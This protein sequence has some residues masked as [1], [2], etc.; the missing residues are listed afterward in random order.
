MKPL[1]INKDSCSPVSSN[2]VT[3][4]GPDIECIGLC[5][6]DSIT[7]VV[8]ELA[9]KLCEILGKLDVDNYDLECLNITT[10]PPE[11]FE[12]LLQILIE[13]ICEIQ[14]TPCPPCEDGANGN[15]VV[16]AYEP[17]GENCEFGGVVITTYNGTTNLPI[18]GSAVYVCNGQDGEDGTPGTTGGPGTPG[19]RGTSG[20]N[21]DYVVQ[22]AEPAGV[23]CECGGIKIEN[24]SGVDNSLISTQYICSACNYG[25]FE[26]QSQPVSLAKVAP[27]MDTTKICVGTV[28][29][30]SEV[31]DD[32]SAYNPATG[33][34]TCPATGVYNMS[35]FINYSRETGTG[36]FDAGTPGMFGAG[37]FS[38]TGC[39]NY[40]SGWMSPIITQKHVNIVGTVLNKSIPAGTQLCLKVI[41]ATNYDYVSESG[42]II[43]WSI[44]RVK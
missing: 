22:I 24:R 12:D 9:T 11:T 25:G 1:N 31:Y 5:K 18:P 23:N 17:A 13:K 35:F 32:D 21:G 7:E 33:I 8:Y 3:W 44:Q 15:Y 27:G 39:N 41:N 20:N 4:N 38:P 29:Q 28:Q 43:R 34:W 10:C 26:A 40:C 19:T 37:I 16:T 36:F 42:D 30:V 6:G 14:A 2:C